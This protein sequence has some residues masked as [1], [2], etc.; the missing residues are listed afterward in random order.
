MRTGGGSGLAIVAFLALSACTVE[1]AT[2]G[3]GAPGSG[4]AGS[5]GTTSSGAAGSSA[6]SAG[7]TTSAGGSSGAGGSATGGSAGVDTD[8]SADGSAPVDGAIVD[9]S[10][11]GGAVTCFAEDPNN[12]EAG[13][14]S[15]S[16]LPYYTQVCAD[17][18]GGHAP[19]GASICDDLDQDIKIAAA[20]ELF[21]CLKSIP[22]AD[23][24]A[25]ACSAAHDTAAGDCSKKIFNRSTC[26]VP[27]G[28]VD[29]GAY[30]CAQIVA[31]CPSDGGAGGITL[32][33][34]QAWLNP[35]NAA[36]RQRIIACY[37]DPG[38]PAGTSCGD[39]FENEC[40]FPP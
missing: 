21:D 32:A 1:P 17:D 34:C 11:E 33:Q 8:A 38:T 10:S 25:D 12:G 5:A 23:A 40:V 7:S 26:A 9:G 19:L 35:F 22:G 30:G 16:S 28:N 15:C 2:S 4:S 31:S 27:D 20:Q 36:A 13:T 24:G 14:Q 29:G 37:L 18:G 39:K 6:G 3:L